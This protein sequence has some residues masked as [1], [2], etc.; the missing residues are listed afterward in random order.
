MLFAMKLGPVATTEGFVNAYF[1]WTPERN[2]DPILADDDEEGLRAL[3]AAH[4]GVDKSDL[5]CEKALFK[6][7]K[8][9]GFAVGKPD[10]EAIYM[11]A[12]MAM[13]LALGASLDG[14]HPRT[15][16]V[17]NSLASA[18]AELYG[19]EP[20]TH[21]A[22]DQPLHI[23]VQGELEKSYEALVLGADHDPPGLVLFESAG[24]AARVIAG[25]ELD[26]EDHIAF[27]Y[28]ESPEY[29][30]DAIDAA[31]HMPRYPRAISWQ[32]GEEE[33]I[34]SA[35]ILVLVNVIVG[36]MHMIEGGHDGLTMGIP[37]DGEQAPPPITVD[38]SDG[39]L[40]A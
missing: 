3:L 21:F 30:V 29:A 37:I 1:A 13:L 35:E 14:H 5:R 40:L 39:P 12:S 36:L 15:L 26:D 32:E 7:G 23:R 6:A 33:P 16:V 9:L 34:D 18:S 10:Q 2:P 27:F 11:K 25:G 28:E 19:M 24:A 17:V 38:L 31:V 4:P 8:P 20:W 22:E